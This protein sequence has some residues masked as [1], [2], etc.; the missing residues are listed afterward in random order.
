MYYCVLQ[1][2]VTAFGACGGPMVGVFLLAGAFPWG[3]KYVSSFLT[4]VFTS[5]PS[6]LSSSLLPSS[7]VVYLSSC[8]RRRQFFSEALLYCCFLVFRNS[9][10]WWVHF[11][12]SVLFCQPHQQLFTHSSNTRVILWPLNP[13]S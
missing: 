9:L 12:R 7:S 5:A 10:L 3:N 13:P 1:L 4:C 6:C 8:T 2:A 11:P